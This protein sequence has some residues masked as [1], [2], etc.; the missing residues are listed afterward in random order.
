MLRIGGLEPELADRLYEAGIISL[1]EFTEASLTELEDLTR[2]PQA[3]LEGM[4][5]EAA[6]LLLEQESVQA[7]DVDETGESGDDREEIQDSKQAQGE[8]VQE[9]VPGE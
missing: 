7:E 1:Q 8:T 4:L 6:R 2:L 5:A 9:Q 3:V